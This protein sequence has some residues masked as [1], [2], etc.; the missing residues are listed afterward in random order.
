MPVI[1]TF[2]VPNLFSFTFRAGPTLPGLL[3]GTVHDE[4]SPS[5]T[6]DCEAS[7]KVNTIAPVPSYGRGKTV[8]SPCGTLS[9]LPLEIRIMI[10]RNVL[11]YKS[12]IDQPHMF[13]GLHL[14][15]LAEG[16]RHFE[17]ID[18]ALLRTCKAIYCEAILIL[19]GTNGFRFLKPSDIK[20]FA[21]AGLGST[22]FGFY[23]NNTT[24]KPSSAVQNALYGRLTMIRR[25]N[26]KLKPEHKGDDLQKI[27]SYWSDFFYP[28]EEQ[29]QLI[30]FPDLKF[31]V[32]DF[33]DWKLKHGNSSKIRVC[34][35]SC[36][37]YHLYQHSL[38]FGAWRLPLGFGWSKIS[39]SIPDILPDS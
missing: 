3:N 32:L 31:L 39:L 23:R 11:K 21:H 13:L 22:P 27:W 33:T 20:E 4:S 18:S 15:I 37:F 36:I 6:N 14:P 19:Y 8:S 17:A 9:K 25:I 10:Y 26:L 1:F 7:K 34:R 24:R 28:P 35:Y 16:G 29:D 5:V 30:A 12:H 38:S 2:G